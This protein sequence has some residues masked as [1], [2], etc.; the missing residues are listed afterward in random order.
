MTNPVFDNVLALMKQ[1]MDTAENEMQRLYGIHQRLEALKQ[2]ERELQ[3][4][5]NELA[6]Q[7]SR[8]RQQ[9]A[10]NEHAAT[11]R[12]ADGERNREQI[13][14]S[15]N[16]RAKSII[17]DGQKA[18]YLLIEE[19][20]KQIVPYREQIAAAKQEFESIRAHTSSVNEQLLSAQKMFAQ[21]QQ[22]AAALTNVQLRSG[23]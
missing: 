17:E 14:A 5:V 10:D 20:Q 1:A 3:K 9:I 19:A 16:D 7:L 12:V 13:I 21:L 8:T 23:T 15:A 22:A 4:A 6:P 11:Q 2:Q 18:A